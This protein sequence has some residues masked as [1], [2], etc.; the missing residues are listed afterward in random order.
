[1]DQKLI[2]NSKIHLDRLWQG[3]TIQVDFNLPQ[4]FNLTYMGNDGKEH[5]PV[6]IHRVVLG[7]IRRFFGALIE[8]LCR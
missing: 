6:M 3:P 2:L 8:N 4:R 7:S 5:T 1:M